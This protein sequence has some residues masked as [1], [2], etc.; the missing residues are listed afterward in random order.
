MPPT[1]ID[2]R[3]A[4]DPRDVVHRAVQMLAEGRCVGFP[5]ETDYVVAANVRDPAAVVRLTKLVEPRRGEP[6]LSL[7]LKSADEALDWAPHLPAPVRRLARRCWPGPVVTLVRGDAPEALVHRLPEAVRPA[8]LADGRLRLRVP[9]HPMLAESLR[10][11]A[12]P[13]ALAE[14]LVD[15]RCATTA[16]EL[17]SRAGDGVGLVIDD[18]GVRYPQ[19]ATTIAVT[20]GSLEVVRPGIVAAD[21]LRRLSSLMVLFVCTGNTCRS[22]MAEA[23]FRQ[24]VA[25][26]LGCRA[27]EIEQH[28]IVASS[29]GLAAWAGAPAS[30]GALE[31]MAEIG[32]DLAGHESQPITDALVRQADVILTMTGSHRTAL[33]AQFPEAGG[34]VE[35]LSPDRQDVSDPIGGPL[36]TYRACAAQIRGHL[37][38]R[39]A[40]LL[41]APS[42]RDPGGKTRE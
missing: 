16:A 7:A 2:L 26:R 35:M 34:R 13:L 32:A 38:A 6:A 18:G 31:A 23:Q 42:G 33:L 40:T 41:D 30:A 4:D 10:M 5:T 9:G 21:T 3:R 29:A 36:P 20:D 19:E 37:L 11:H 28:G 12:G 15:G 17:L 39:L 14:P 27:D 22:P 8:L 1:V 25:E 24:L